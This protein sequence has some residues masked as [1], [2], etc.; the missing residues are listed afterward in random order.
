MVTVTDIIKVSPDLV[1]LVD[2]GDYATRVEPVDT[3]TYLTLKRNYISFI[4]GGGDKQM[5]YYKEFQGSILIISYELYERISLEK[6]ET[7]DFSVLL[8]KRPRLSFIK[9]VKHFFYDRKRKDIHPSAQIGEGVE[10]GSGVVIHANV[11]VYDGVIIGKNCKIKA[12]TVLGGTG[13]GYEQDEYGQWHSFPHIGKLVIM[14]NVEIGSNCSIDRGTIK[15]T[16]IRSGVKID[17]NVHIAHNV[18]IDENSIITAGVT[19]AG[20]VSVGK[21]CWF[22]CGSVIRD[23]VKIGNNVLVG[24]GAA[25]VSDVPDDTKVK[26]VPAKPF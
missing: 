5:K 15:D 20:S 24:I 18:I 10:L 17:N 21:N 4:K 19:F 8:S 7:G 14:D 23:N 13:F 6:E 3:T 9:L 2:R 25:V 26:G 1:V 16:I 22:A 11:T 12:G